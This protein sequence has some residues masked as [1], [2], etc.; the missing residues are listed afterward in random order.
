MSLHS[1]YNIVALA[2]FALGAAA[3][4]TAAILFVSQRL[5]EV[6]SVWHK[7]PASARRTTG[8][9]AQ[10]RTP[11]QPTGGRNTSVLNQ[12]TNTANGTRPANDPESFAPGTSVL[13][14]SVN[15]ANGT[16]LLNSQA[17]VAAGTT[18]LKAKPTAPSTASGGTVQLKHP[19]A[20]GGTVQLKPPTASGGTVQLK[21]PTAS[22]G[23]VQLK[24]PTASGGTVQ[25][26][27]P[28]ASGGTVQLKPSTASGGTVQ[29]KHPT[30]SGGTVQLKYPT[31][32]GG[33]NPLK[34]PPTATGGTTMLRV[35]PGA[36]AARVRRTEDTV[37]AHVLGAYAASIRP[38]R[39]EPPAAFRIVKDEVVVHTSEVI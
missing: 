37:S 32:S 6:M 13:D 8:H 4:I 21:H 25:L 33:T 22:G 38:N 39:S 30:A 35:T 36:P 16:T 34:A 20:S 12:S 23:T 15:A 7:R 14:R 19:T 9:T 1:V 27:H 28:T 29:L 31:A 10:V 18:L 24:H 26:K 2:A 3:L 5:W 17:D 11:P